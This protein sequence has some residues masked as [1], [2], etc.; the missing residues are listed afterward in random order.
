MDRVLSASGDHVFS[1]ANGMNSVTAIA[2]NGARVVVT[3]GN[4]GGPAPQPL[5]QAYDAAGTRLAL[6]E[7]V[8]KFESGFGS[9]DALA[10]GA[11]GRIWWNLHFRDLPP[12]D[13]LELPYLLV[14]HE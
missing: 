1:K 8:D 14:L 11:S 13:F 3:G 6:P 9:V 5:L 7:T 2:S 10:I 12:S 4:L